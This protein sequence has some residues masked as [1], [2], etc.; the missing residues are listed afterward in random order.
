[1]GKKTI[2]DL[3]PGLYRNIAKYMGK[4]SITSKALNTYKR[5]IANKN[6][7]IEN[8]ILHSGMNGKK[9]ERLQSKVKTGV[10]RPKKITADELNRRDKMLYNI[11]HKNK[12][13][14]I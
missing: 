11:I 5:K 13:K 14:F 4:P 10:I 1:M 2:K 8:L 7:V 6:A 9:I 12:S 3:P